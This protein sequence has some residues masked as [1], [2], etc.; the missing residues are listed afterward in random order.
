MQAAH[1][2]TVPSRE[3]PAPHPDNW[4]TYCANYMLSFEVKLWGLRVR[5]T[6][7]ASV[8]SVLQHFQRVIPH[9]LDSGP[10]KVITAAYQVKYN[11]KK[12]KK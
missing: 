9:Q 12:M 10:D 1:I 5:A 2:S 6:N 4:N 8:P 7:T 3:E 11:A